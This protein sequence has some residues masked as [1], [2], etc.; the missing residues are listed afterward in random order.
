MSHGFKFSLK[1]SYINDASIILPVKYKPTV[2]TVSFCIYIYILFH[3]LKSTD[4]FGGN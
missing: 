3:F 4:L 2:S 1:R